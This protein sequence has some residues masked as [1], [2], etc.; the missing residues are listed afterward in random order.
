MSRSRQYYENRQ[1]ICQW[2]KMGRKMEKQKTALNTV[3]TDMDL[4][5]I[6]T[7]FSQILPRYS[8]T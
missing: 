6:L 3:C 7:A 4:N 1:L 2:L 5:I 8:E